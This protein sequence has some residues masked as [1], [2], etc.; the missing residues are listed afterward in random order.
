MNRIMINHQQE[1]LEVNLDSC[2]KCLSSSS[3]KEFSKK[4]SRVSGIV[5]GEM[6]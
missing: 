5:I 6:R 3:V 4:F 1:K 2:I